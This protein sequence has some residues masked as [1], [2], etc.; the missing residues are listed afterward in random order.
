[1]LRSFHRD[2]QR[3]RSQLSLL[4]PLPSATSRTW[5]HELLSES[6]FSIRLRDEHLL[7]LLLRSH[8][9]SHLT[10]AL[11]RR[12]GPTRRIAP[13]ILSPV[14][15]VT[16]AVLLAAAWRQYGG[17]DESRPVR[18]VP[19]PPGR[20]IRRCASADLREHVRSVQHLRAVY[21]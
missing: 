5:F 2:A 10:G 15:G 4:C 20:R 21:E 8:V 18:R 11:T 17:W 7:R 3:L 1:M 9:H 19:A 6:A 16:W 13:G 12:G 14:V